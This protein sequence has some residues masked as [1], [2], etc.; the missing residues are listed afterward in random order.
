MITKQFNIIVT[1]LLLS[2]VTGLSGLVLAQTD[3]ILIQAI[4]GPI[5][6]VS[7]IML[8][9]CIGAFSQLWMRK[10]KT[11]DHYT[12]TGL[13][14]R[15]ASQL[16]TNDGVFVIVADSR[17]LT[18]DLN[19]FYIQLKS[20]YKGVTPYKAIRRE[21]WLTFGYSRTE[22]NALKFFMVEIGAGTAM[23]N[24]GLKMTLPPAPTIDLIRGRS[25]KQKLTRPK[26]AQNAEFAQNVQKLPD[27]YK[28]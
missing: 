6:I 18:F 22:V 9:S 15:V 26:R 11:Y 14:Q 25:G 7:F 13:L 5:A 3:S 12:S 19:Y 10:P 8:L 21:K 20:D 2:A 17:K 16:V 1:G 28:K 24:G 4:F 27:K 23:G